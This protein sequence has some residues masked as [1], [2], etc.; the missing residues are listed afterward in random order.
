M[1]AFPPYSQRF[2]FLLLSHSLLLA[3]VLVGPT[4]AGESSLKLQTLLEEALLR[5]PDI[6]SA[7]QRWEASQA[8]IPQVQTL[9]DPQVLFGYQ[10]MPMVE[11][12]EGPVYGLS[13]KFPFPGKLALK[14]EVAA[15]QA[16]RIEQE[17]LATKLHVIAQL[18][19]LP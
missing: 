7:R 5:N 10:R 9:P 17:Y 2:L 3:C 15:R 12:L 4:F 16:D 11:P 1:N 14:G 13:Q 18:K 8:I 19:Q 6:Q